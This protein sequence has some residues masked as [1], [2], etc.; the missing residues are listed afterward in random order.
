MDDIRLVV[1]LGNPSREYAGTRHNVGWRVVEKLAADAGARWQQAAKFDAEI[2]EAR[3]AGR[4]IVLAKPVTF[5]NLSGRACVALLHW[6]KVAPEQM[7]VVT[8]DADLDVGRLRLRLKGSSGGH[9][10]LKSIVEMSGTEQFPRVRV[11]I[12]RPMRRSEGAPENALVDFVL[13]KFRKEEQA[14]A[15]E[16]VARAAAAVACAIER[17][18]DAAMNEFNG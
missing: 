14:A 11:G 5:M 16:A 7:L 10:G 4:K 17:G 2:A 3:L 8:D 1:G 18:M 15:D 6:H 12:G 9:N 13:S